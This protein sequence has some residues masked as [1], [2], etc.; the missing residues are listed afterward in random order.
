MRLRTPLIGYENNRWA[1]SLP[2]AFIE[3]IIYLVI[4][5]IRQVWSN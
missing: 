4:A 1:A 5:P 3:N 2:V